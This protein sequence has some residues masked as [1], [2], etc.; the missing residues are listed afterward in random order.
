MRRTSLVVTDEEGNTILDGP[1]PVREDEEAMKKAIARDAERRR[2][3]TQ[4]EK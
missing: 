1:D 3:D 4:R 2:K